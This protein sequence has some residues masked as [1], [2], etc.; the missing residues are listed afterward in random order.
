MDKKPFLKFLIIFLIVSMS[1]GRK[2]KPMGS[3]FPETLPH[4]HLMKIIKGEKAKREVNKLHG[5]EIHLKNAW[6][7]H[8]RGS[9]SQGNWHDATIWVSEAYTKK[10]AESQTKNMMEKI[11]QNPKSPFHH[12]KIKNTNEQNYIPSQAWGKTCCISKNLLVFWISTTPEI[13]DR[14]LNYYLSHSFPKV[15]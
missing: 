2:P 11:M 4:L 14:V 8:Y 12:F 9:F 7:A 13:F 6:I 10:E 3:L 15:S 5:T 1:C